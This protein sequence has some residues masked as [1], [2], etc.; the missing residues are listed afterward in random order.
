VQS[1]SA[2]VAPRAPER[3]DGLPWGRGR[4]LVGGGSLLLF[5]GSVRAG[6]SRLFASPLLEFATHLVRQRLGEEEVGVLRIDGLLPTTHGSLDI[7]A[8]NV[9]NPSITS[10]AG[11]HDG[12]GPDA[13]SSSGGSERSF[14]SPPGEGA[15]VSVSS[16]ARSP[17]SLAKARAVATT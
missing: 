9:V 12:R 10:S 14:S 1:L 17:S 4:R 11:I 7:G 6:M 5:Q 3:P 15:S 16:A 8:R 13:C 2:S